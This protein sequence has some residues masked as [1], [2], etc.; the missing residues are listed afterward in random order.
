MHKCLLVEIPGPAV[1]A[2][3]MKIG[4]PPPLFAKPPE[5]SWPL[6]PTCRQLLDRFE[7]DA[8]TARP[9]RVACR[10]ASWEEAEARRLGKRAEQRVA[11][12]R[13]AA[14]LSWLGAALCRGGRLKE[15]AQTFDEAIEVHGKG[16]SVDTWLFLALAQQRLGRGAEARSN[17]ARFE[18]GRE[19]RKFATGQERTRWQLLHEETRRPILT[20]P[21]AIRDAGHSDTSGHGALRHPDE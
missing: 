11:A 12:R 10:V 13:D 17:L 6:P 7:K 2:R 8:R 1:A 9:L 14:T 21:R 5:K 16:A 19:G 15:A 4:P 18:K 20:V 3:R